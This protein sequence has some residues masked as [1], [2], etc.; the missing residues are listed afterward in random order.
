MSA[1]G[2]ASKMLESITALFWAEAD[3]H[4]CSKG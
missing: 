2:G 1:D 4:P 3:V